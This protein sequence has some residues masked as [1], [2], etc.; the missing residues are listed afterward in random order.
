MPKKYTG[1]SLLLPLQ[2]TGYTFDPIG[3]TGSVDERI[4]AH[5]REQLPDF[6]V[7][8]YSTF[9]S[10]IDAYY[11]WMEQYGNPRA[12]SV[13]LK[14]Y[15]DIDET[16][17]EFIVYFREQ[18]VEGLPVVLANGVNEKTLIK[19]ISDMYKTKGSRKSFE[20]LFRI[21][22]NTNISL[23]FPKDRLLKL[24]TSTF[25]DKRFLRVSPNFDLDVAKNLENTLAIQRTKTGGTINATGLINKVEYGYRNGIDFFSLEL[26]NVSGFFNTTRPIELSPLGS[27]GGI[28]YSNVFPT[29][30]SLIVVSSGSNYNLNDIVTVSDS[31]GNVLLRGIVDNLS[32]LGG[33]RGFN[34]IDNFGIYTDS[35]GITYSIETLTG[36]GAVLEA[37]SQVVLSPGPDTYA[38][39]SGKLSGRSFIQDSFFFQNFSYIIRVNQRLETF[40]DAVRSIIHPAGTIMFSEFIQETAIT[41]ND[42]LNTDIIGNYTPIIGHFLPHTFGTTIDPRGFTFTTPAGTT[43]IDFYPIGYNG[44][45]GRTF[46]EFINSV[47]SSITY[48]TPHINPSNGITHDPYKIW[49]SAGTSIPFDGFESSRTLVNGALGSTGYLGLTQ[50]D[51]GEYVGLFGMFPVGSSRTNTLTYAGFGLTHYGGYVSPYETFTVGGYSGGQVTFVGDTD[52][53]TADYWIVHRHV[54]SMGIEN[55]GTTGS[56]PLIR[57]PIAPTTSVTKVYNP[58]LPTADGYSTKEGKGFTL[59]N[60]FYTVGEYVRQTRPRESQAIG[61]V[62]AVEAGAYAHGNIETLGDPMYNLAIDYLTVEVLNGFFTAEEDITKVKRPVIGD[63]SGTSRFIDSSYNEDIHTIGENVYDTS[64]MEVPIEIMTE[65]I[66]FS[67]FRS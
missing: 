36:T 14:T 18:Y 24:S 51:D 33:I 57:I 40:A 45:D 3:F 35:E 41:A 6:I 5:L 53:S 44:Q 67:Y 37:T 38:D 15:A 29:L 32:P 64:W 55:L 59:S 39:D 47:W 65:K 56:N 63:T 54:N 10:F 12:E 62:I 26:E 61:K 27:T 43:H 60:G 25:Q 34:Y 23:E 9:T 28:Y 31:S 2:I 19:R 49:T 46:G 58:I 52:S 13:R 1:G 66:Q 20:L 50:D 8:D 7:S 11:E 48:G 21:L 17:N 22:F 42:G 30:D 16:L 4:S